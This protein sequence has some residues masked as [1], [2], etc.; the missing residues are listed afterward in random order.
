MLP[1]MASAARLQS[2]PPEA[3]ARTNAALAEELRRRGAATAQ[4]PHAGDEEL[5][6]NLHDKGP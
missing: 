2:N 6:S 4:S 1:D 5:E 3:Q